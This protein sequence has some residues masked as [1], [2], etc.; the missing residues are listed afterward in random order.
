MI[1]AFCLSQFTEEKLRLQPWLTVHRVGIGL[2]DQGHEVHVVTDGDSRA[3]VDG[4][5]IHKVQSLRGTNSSEIRGLLQSIQPNSVV[6]S[7][8]PLSL[9]TSGWYKILRQFAAFA[10]LSYSFYKPKQIV[11]AFPHLS[12]RE[13]HEYGR[14]LLVPRHLWV[15]R[16]V[17]LFNGVICQSRH[18]GRAIAIQTGSR[19]PIHTIPPG[20]D[21]DLWTFMGGSSKRDG[22]DLL[23]L[24]IGA[25]SGIRGFF[26]MLDAFAQS[27]EFGIG[28]KILARGAD[29]RAIKKIEVEIARRDLKDRVL[30]RGG[31]MEIDELRREIHNAT[32]VLLPFILIPSELPVSVMESISCGTPV[33]V[34]DIDGLPEAV[35]KAGVV[36]PPGDVSS[37]ALAIQKLHHDKKHLADLNAA[38]IRRRKEM[39]SW[40]SV[41]SRWRD[42]LKG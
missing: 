31:W 18:T 7:V 39:L 36:V 4:I 15:K 35:G 24:Y 10:Y 23:F 3:R 29:K 38:C 16:L 21:R 5:L 9:L 30:V 11:K 20:I 19:I 26:V 28:L 17:H 8:T 6:V 33:L 14:Q 27:L 41:C 13:Q 2:L 12:W 25:A 1:V 42:V 32:A 22:S 37:L 34:S 40:H